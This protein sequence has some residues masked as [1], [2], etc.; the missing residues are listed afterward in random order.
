MLPLLSADIWTLFA[1]HSPV[2]ETDADKP[3]TTNGQYA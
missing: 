2:G 3:Q 1:C